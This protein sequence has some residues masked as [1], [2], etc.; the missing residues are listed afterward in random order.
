MTTG[1][2][3]NIGRPRSHDR[4]PVL[5]FHHQQDSWIIAILKILDTNTDIL[6]DN[7]SAQA[8]ISTFKEK[9]VTEMR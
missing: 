4:N 8:V 7:S 5:I 3:V 2:I 6:Q 1:S 9:I